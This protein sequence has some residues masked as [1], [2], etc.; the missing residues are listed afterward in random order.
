MQNK[1]R[2]NIKTNKLLEYYKIKKIKLE[3]YSMDREKNQNNR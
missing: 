1:N 3:L 2:R